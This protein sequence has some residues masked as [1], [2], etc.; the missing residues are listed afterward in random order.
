MKF[1]PATASDTH[2]IDELIALRAA[3]DGREA[4]SEYKT[5]MRSEHRVVELVATENSAIVGYGVAAQHGAGSLG[6]E[7]LAHPDGDAVPVLTGLITHIR[8]ALPTGAAGYVWAWR[9][10]ERAVIEGLGLTVERVL[11]TMERN[12]GAADAAA[13]TAP[14]GVKL[15]TFEVGVDEE[16]WLEANRK[17]FAGHPETAAIDRHDLDRRV[18]EP[19]F[20]ASGF[21]LAERAGEI[22]GYCWT[23]LHPRTTEQAIGE[24][25][26]IGV[27]PTA[28]NSGLGQV[29][30]DAGLADLAG[31]Q[32]AQRAIL[33]VD[34]TDARLRAF[35]EKRGFV[36]TFEINAYGL[37]AQP[38]R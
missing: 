26:I 3:A 9:P 21:I 10:A 29:L 8:T 34:G 5:L 14:H 35:Y 15:R 19:W 11:A 1:R 6:V 33:H 25:Y 7:V 28:R 22:V 18:E 37:S 30:L 27:V 32:G 12:V 2:P 20:D 36:R 17:A 13:P 4:I 31:R 16:L 23:K 24:I 38:N